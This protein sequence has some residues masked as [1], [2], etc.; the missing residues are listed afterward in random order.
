[1]GK[2]PSSE[3][4]A[5]CIHVVTGLSYGWKKA[6]LI[7][8]DIKPDN[9]FLSTDGDVKLGDL[10][11]AKSLSQEN[12]LTMTGASMGTPLYISP[13]QTEGRKDIT[14]STDIYSLGCMLFHLVSGQAPYHG[15]TPFS[16]MLKHVSAPIPDLR[17][18]CAG[19]P[20]S[21]A[22]VVQ[23]MMAKSPN[24]RQSSYE[25]LAADL[26]TAYGLLM[27]PADPQPHNDLETP[28]QEAHRVVHGDA[29]GIPA[30][31]KAS[32]FL[33]PVI[34]S[35]M[36][37]FA[38]L[39]AYKSGL[40]TT[41]KKL[42]SARHQTVDLLALVDPARDRVM[43]GNL[44]KSNKWEKKGSVLSYVSDSKAGKIVPP[45]ALHAREYE[46][47]IHYKRLGGDGQF[48]I[49]VPLPEEKI[50]PLVLD[51]EGKKVVHERGLP[52]WPANLAPAG[53][54]VIHVN[55]GEGEGLD[56]LGFDLGEGRVLPSWTGRLKEYS[57]A[58]EYHPDFP[59]KPVTSI[60][61]MR[62]SYEFSKWT[63]TVFRGSVEVLR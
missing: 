45:V 30:R 55:L 61:S 43:P 48:H 3:A 8:R 51:R 24:D 11:L 31:K 19:C 35:L 32:R 1:M 23:K 7:H 59:K 36:V 57:R 41:L 52:T 42:K 16:V 6:Q 39:I 37:V 29:S 49:D 47:E 13:E 4:L 25:A 38:F 21:L 9:I 26:Q 50:V 20:D 27:S 63:L 58:L 14:F 40:L 60:F 56:T 5:I 15:D 18:A 34:A 53:K 44:G 10:G 17:D 62:D 12:S 2:L 54:I 28:H 22:A 33:V 46:I